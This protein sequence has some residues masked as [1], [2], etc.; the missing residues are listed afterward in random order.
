MTR[1]L[2]PCLAHRDV[3][4]LGEEEQLGLTY[5][6]SARHVGSLAGQQAGDVIAARQAPGLLS[7]QHSAQQAWP[8][9]YAVKHWPTSPAALLPISSFALLLQLEAMT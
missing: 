5:S 3:A 1:S 9:L 6:P 4:Y 8:A 2:Q 7:L